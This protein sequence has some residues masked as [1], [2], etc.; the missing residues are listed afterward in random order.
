MY[1]QNGSGLLDRLKLNYFS[2]RLTVIL[3]ILISLCVLVLAYL[4]FKRR[5]S[6]ETFEGERVFAKES[7]GGENPINQVDSEG[8]Q[9]KQKQDKVD[10]TNELVLYYAT[11]CGYSKQFL[12]EW[13]KFVEYAKNNLPHL[14]VTGV[15]CEGGNEPICMQKGIEGYP[16]VMLYMYD[17]REIPFEG[18]R[19]KDALVAFVSKN[20]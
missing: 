14:K 13:E 15:R 17:G 16:M 4:W 11:W 1:N 12:P 7:K 20:L 6:K 3:S 8:Q 9:I 2:G 18:D 10:T 19:T 5:W